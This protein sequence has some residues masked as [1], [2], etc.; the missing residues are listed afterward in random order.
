MWVD[1]WEDDGE[2]L[3]IKFNFGLFKFKSWLL[4][5]EIG[6]MVVV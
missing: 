3:W 4:C 6:V 2:L 5:L 1:G